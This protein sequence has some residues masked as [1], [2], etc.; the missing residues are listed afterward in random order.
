MPTVRCGGVAHAESSGRGVPERVQAALVDLGQ[1][2][3]VL[4][5]GLEPR[6]EPYCQA[7]VGRGGGGRAFHS[8]QLGRIVPR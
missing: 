2:E 6:Q 1:M 4:R 7:Q 3:T 5:L 8:Q